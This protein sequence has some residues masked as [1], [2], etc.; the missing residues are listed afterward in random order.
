VTYRTQGGTRRC[1]P[2]KPLQIYVVERKQAVD[3]EK[4]RRDWRHWFLIVQNMVKKQSK[5][6][7]LVTH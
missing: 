4:F 3:L 1:K 7:E 6:T 5:V 2:L